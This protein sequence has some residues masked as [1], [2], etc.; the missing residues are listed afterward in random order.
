MWCDNFVK[1]RPETT[2]AEAKN[3]SSGNDIPSE[4][5]E[6]SDSTSSEKDKGNDEKE[7]SGRDN[8]SDGHTATADT[9]RRGGRTSGDA[10]SSKLRMK[11]K[12]A[13]ANV[14]SSMLALL[15]NPTVQQMIESN[16]V[17]LRKWLDV[18]YRR[19]SEMDSV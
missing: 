12:A 6:V 10:S 13:E 7:S 17:K 1:L 8:A 2:A 9:E 15:A 11:R 18:M 3:G 19:V 16:S 14:P 4:G 5:T